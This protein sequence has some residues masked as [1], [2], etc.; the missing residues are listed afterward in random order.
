M[1]LL[2]LATFR[3]GVHPDEHKEATEDLRIERMPFVRSYVL[4]LG[5]HGG[6]PAKPVV[7]VGQSVLRGELIAAA[8]GFVSTCLHAP[9][10]GRVTAID[11]RRHPN[12]ALVEA[13]E[14]E[15]D[16][17]SPQTVR[18]GE[19]LDVDVMPREQF[20]AEVQRAGLVGLGGAAFPAHVKYAL[21]EGRKV[22]ELVIN[23]CEC[24]PYLTCDHR[25]MVERP[26]AVVRGVRILARQLG[27]ERST[28]GVEAN[29]PD[30]VEVLRA[31]IGDD[32]QVRVVPLEVKYP[33]G[34]EKMLIKAIFGVEV[35]AGK[36]P[37]DI[38]MVVNNVGT[39]AS[40]ADWF[41]RRVP[42]IERVVTVAGPGIERPANLLVPVGTPVGE[43]LRQAGGLSQDTRE[44]VMGGPMMGQ[45]LASLDVPVLKGTSGLLA[46]TAQET[47]HPNEYACLK[48]G[49]CLDACA[50]FLNPSRL[51]RLSKAGRHAELE[52]AFV[53]DC[54]ECGACSFA[55]P[56]NIPIVQLI[57]ASKSAI[58]SRRARS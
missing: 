24:E 12:G 7:R 36:L 45:S 44:V 40:L 17:F 49:R 33:Q 14:I 51:A 30:A 5:Q 11:R 57:R 6:K 3:H 50:N 52:Q 9:V 35:P 18:E 20:V 47:A 15:A 22:R 31:A 23:G 13:I 28:I 2:G 1:S 55:C 38:E 8:D 39:M 4:P 29:K 56:S 41:D 19:P 43:V 26:A 10:D 21:P 34:A 48:C 16:A 25:T 42:L 32:P 46:F 37:L 54:M 53:M 27:V 58:R